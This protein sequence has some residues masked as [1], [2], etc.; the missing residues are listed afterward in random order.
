MFLQY[1][2]SIYRTPLVTTTANGHGDC[3]NYDHW[4]DYRRLSH[5]L[6]LSLTLDH[7]SPNQSLRQS[8][9]NTNWHPV[10]HTK[11]HAT[12]PGC[13]DWVTDWRHHH[14][15][16]RNDHFTLVTL[17]ITANRLPAHICWWPFFSY[18]GHLPNQE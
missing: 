14:L 4:L 2:W 1:L 16:G 17:I 7:F 18:I 5:L 9:I 15:V 6:E 10:T 8:P 13:N 11:N 12:T 3:H